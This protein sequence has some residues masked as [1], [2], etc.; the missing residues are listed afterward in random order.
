[1]TEE[2]FERYMNEQIKSA[3]AII[4]LYNEAKEE[5]TKNA[6]TKRIHMKD[7]DELALYDDED[8]VVSLNKIKI[9]YMRYQFKMIDCVYKNGLSI[10]EAYA[11]AG[12]NITESQHWVQYTQDYLKEVC[13][14]PKFR[15]LF[16]E[17][18]N[19]RDKMSIGMTKRAKQIEK[20]NKWI[21]LTYQYLTLK[22]VKRKNYN[23]S[24]IQKL[25]YYRQ[26]ETQDALIYELSKEFIINNSYSND[27][28]KT[29]LGQIYTNL[30][31]KIKPMATSLNDFF[32][33][34]KTKL[35]SFGKKRRVDGYKIL[36]KK[37]TLFI[38]HQMDFL[39]P[40]IMYSHV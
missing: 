33:M 20:T 23:I 8:K 5:I 24:E 28:I 36:D 15:S 3:E 21:A 10:R 12:I 25:I 34:K 16:D 6:L 39:N 40:V 2:K 14:T 31:I 37:N 9:N 30:F 13:S 29:K 18:C 19:E 26:K 22:E 35:N 11:K 17:Y 32:K 38:L 27:E 7:N 4:K 1:M